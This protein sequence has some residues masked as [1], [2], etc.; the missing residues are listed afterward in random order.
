MNSK[1]IKIFS[2]III[3]GLLAVFAG[4][5]YKNN[6]EKFENAAEKLIPARYRKALPKYR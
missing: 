2:V 5:A 3:T 4:I 6:I 1:L